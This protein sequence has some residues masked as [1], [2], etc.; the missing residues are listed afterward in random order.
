[1]VV[2]NRDAYL[3]D[4]FSSETPYTLTRTG[5]IRGREI[6]LLTLYPFSYNPGKQT[7]KLRTHF[8]IREAN[9][10]LD[11]KS[12]QPSIAFIVGA[13]FAKS[14][15][16]HSY[17]EYKKSLGFHVETIPESARVVSGLAITTALD[18]Q[19]QRF[20]PLRASTQRAV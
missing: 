14:D 8:Q 5:S 11:E 2:M 3:K 9:L 20:Q 12:R 17:L 15:S 16:L 4:N 6:F 13:Q 1:M 10:P 7:Y 18:S 19:D